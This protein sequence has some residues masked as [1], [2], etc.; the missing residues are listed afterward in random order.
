VIDR[1]RAATQLCAPA[2]DGGALVRAMH[3]PAA[4]CDEGQLY[5]CSLGTIVDCHATATIASC[6]RGCVVDGASIETSEPVPLVGGAPAPP[7]EREDAFAILC[8]H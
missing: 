2:R 8:S 4:P 3:A 5:R 1:A 6:L 7:V